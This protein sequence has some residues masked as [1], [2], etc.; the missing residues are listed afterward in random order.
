MKIPSQTRLIA[1]LSLLVFIFASMGAV[2][3]QD[4]ETD[5]Y[6]GTISN[7]ADEEFYEVDLQAG[8]AILI[9]GEAISGNLDTYVILLAPDGTT[10]AEN[11]DRD[12][13]VITDSALGYIATESGT[14][15]VIM[16]RYPEQESSGNYRLEI[17]VGSPQILDQLNELIVRVTLSGPEQT[18]D[19]LHFRI[20]FTMRGDDAVTED[21]VDAVVEAV[22]EFYDIEINQL[23]WPPPPSDGTIGGD[24]RYDVYLADIIG[25]GEGAL[26]YASPETIVGDNPNSPNLV[27]TSA[28]T[29][30]L[31]LDNDYEGLDYGDS[32][33]AIGLM[34]TTFAHEF[35]HAI[36][37][38]YDA[39]EPHGWMYEATATWMET[40]AAGKDQDATG[41]VEYAFEYPEL[42]F[43]TLSDPQDGLLQYGEWTFIQML[44]DLYGPTAPADYWSY[45]ARFD[46]WDSMER[47]LDERGT[48]VPEMFAAY[49]LKNLAR[50]YRLAPNFDTT[51]WLEEVIDDFGS[52][53]YT[54]EGVQELGANYF[55][56]TILGAQIR[57]EL[58]NDG[59]T[60]ELWAIGVLGNE[61]LEAYRLNNGGVVDTAPYED[62]YL[63]VFNPNYDNDMDE[64]DYYDYDIL[65][66]SANGSTPLTPT[67]IY[68]ATFFER[69][70]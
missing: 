14:Y 7:R 5:V 24:G 69:L 17:T 38:G 42:C 43:G 70:N 58:D 52:W 3:A 35:N 48:T 36:Q 50:D 26:G 51:V 45:I 46:E 27:E 60:L 31:V 4:G 22:E 59:G 64:C 68:P 15:T 11:D 37:F 29:S 53:T 49:R 28:A 66:D 30:Y 21:Y 54:G 61:K 34:R 39:Q 62:F 20:H 10:L 13:G 16:T 56:L 44:S 9:I 2:Y 8:E 33:T 63:M 19:T 65:V 6:Q 12:L 57:A 67:Y 25:G 55:R 40:A 1:L 18:V 47:F 32:V 41:Y 23:G